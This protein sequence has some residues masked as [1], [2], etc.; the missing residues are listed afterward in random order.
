MKNKIAVV[1]GGTGFIGRQIVRE[2]ASQGVRVKVATRVPE[3]A[4][5]LKPYGAVGQVVPVLCDYSKPES[6]HDITRGAD[7]VVN[8]VGILFQKGKAKFSKVHTD[9]PANIAQACVDNAVDR[10]VHISALGCENGASKYAKS[11][12]AGEEAIKEIFPK[13]T[14]LRPSVVFGP[15]DDFFNKFAEMSVYPIMLPLIGGGKTKFQPVYVGDVAD[16]V[17][18]ALTFSSSGN[19]NPC[20]Q[21]Y[22]LGGPE[23]VSFKD[24]Y[25]LIAK[26]TGRKRILLPLPFCMA[27]VMAMCMSLLPKPPLTCDQVTSLKQDNVLS[28][29]SLSLADLGIHPK[30]M[31]SVV[32]D[33]LERYRS[34]GKFASELEASNPA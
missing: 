33:Y 2:L 20:G 17:M 15:D 26:Y 34:G 14:I 18:C 6:I 32:P 19:Q 23:V 24:I 29:T 31:A 9:L 22:E 3:S 1:F 7:F 25:K 10:F 30:A 4:Y 5:F 12:L 13:V 21:T 16:A 8:S 11:K 27:K 28:E